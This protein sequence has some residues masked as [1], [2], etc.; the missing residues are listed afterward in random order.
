MSQRGYR[1]I[2]AGFLCCH[3]PDRYPES[4]IFSRCPMA[5]IGYHWLPFLIK[6]ALLNVSPLMAKQSCPTR[7]A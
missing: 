1:K 6:I 7:T 4:F 3:P 2:D 5:A